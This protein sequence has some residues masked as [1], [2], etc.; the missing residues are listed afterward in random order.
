MVRFKETSL[1][2][3]I[4]CA[5]AMTVEAVTMAAEPRAMAGR[6]EHIG[7]TNE[8]HW[9]L[10]DP[11]S[12]DPMALLDDRF[13][14][15]S[16]SGGSG[17]IQGTRDESGSGSPVIIVEDV[18]PEFWAEPSA[19]K[20]FQRGPSTY[21]G[22]GNDL[23]PREWAGRPDS[24]RRAYALDPGSKQYDPA[25]PL[26]EGVVIE[27]QLSPGSVRLR[28]QARPGRIYVVESTPALGQLFQPL[29]TV[30]SLEDG[31]V[32]LQFPRT[33]ARRFYRVAEQVY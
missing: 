32:V 14:R 26:T 10:R 4:L 15:L 5:L 18:S 33:S 24:D 17:I 8:I 9:V 13:G 27:I 21:S 2:A 28:W 1:R 22:F 3:L 30:S 16:A 6:W 31:P 12:G 23:G 7:E 11:L 20:M 29:Q 25:P 19:W